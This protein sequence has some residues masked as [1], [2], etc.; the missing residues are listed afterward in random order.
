MN[1]ATRL[2]IESAGMLPLRTV[3]GLVFLVHGG[4]KLFYFGVAGVAD[5]LSKLGFVFPQ[6]FAVLLIAIEVAGAIAI[7]FGL[8]TRAA[9]LVLALEMVIA[10]FVARVGGGFFTP[11]GYEFE[12]T[13]FGACLTLAAVGAGGISIDAML[14]QRRALSHTEPRP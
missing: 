9:G 6:Q 13:L 4:Q 3:V 14:K 7:L 5:M 12:L 8:Y 10:I 1:T 2:R 11:Y